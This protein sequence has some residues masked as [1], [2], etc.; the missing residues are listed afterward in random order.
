MVD[1]HV[2]VTL[3]ERLLLKV[4]RS[5]LTLRCK[6]DC[7]LCSFCTDL[8]LF[9]TPLSTA[10]CACSGGAEGEADVDETKLKL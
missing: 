9:R 1:D 7:L 5:N 10:T 3:L 8:C 6:G 4:R 2:D